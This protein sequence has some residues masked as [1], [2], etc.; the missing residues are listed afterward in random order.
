[1]FNPIYRFVINR[2][3]HKAIVRGFLPAVF[4]LLILG[5]LRSTSA[6]QSQ[7]VPYHV[8]SVKRIYWTDHQLNTQT[9]EIWRSNADG[10]S[11]ERIVFGLR[12][13]RG[14]E[15]DT[16]MSHVYW[17]DRTDDTLGRANFDGTEKSV[18]FCSG[19]ITPDDLVLDL[20]R[21]KMYWTE[22]TA[23]RIRWSSMDNC[24]PQTLSITGGVVEPVGI[25]LAHD[26]IY[27]AEASSKRIKRANLDGTGVETVIA[28]LWTP[29]EMAFDVDAGYMYV[30]ES[31]ENTPGYGGR[32]V[33][34]PLNGGSFVTIVPNLDNPRGIALDLE[35]SHIY[36]ID[37]GKS[38]L[39]R[40]DL[41][42]NNIITIQSGG[43]SLSFARSLALEPEP[44]VTCY[45][46]SLNRT[47]N[48][49]Y[50][51]ASPSNS[52]GC[53]SG[54]YTAGAN[55]NL[56]AQADNGW[57]VGSWSG[58]NSNSSTSNNNSV[59]MPN[60]NHTATV[61][62]VEIITCYSLL[63]QHTGSGSNP[64][65]G[66]GNSSGCPNKQYIAGA[67]INL[68]ANPNSGWV[69]EGWTGTNNNSSTSLS[70]TVTMPS[71]NHTVIAHYKGQTNCYT[72]LLKHTG[73]GNDP[74]PS[75]PSSPDCAV[76]QYRAGALISLTADPAQTW[77]VKSW[78]GT[79]N[80]SSTAE[81]NNVIMPGGSHTVIV[82][83]A[84]PACYLLQLTREGPGGAPTATPANSTGC[85]AGQYL[86]D[87]AIVLTA[88]PS[89]GAEI[90]DWYG[91]ID[92]TA[93]SLTNIVLMPASNHQAGVR[94]R[95]IQLAA[96]RTLLPGVLKPVPVVA[97]TC[98]AGEREIEPNN[99]RPEAG[100]N[101]PFCFSRTYAG[102]P[103]DS[104]D[105]FAYDINTPG[106]INM[107]VNNH[108]GKNVQLILSNINGTTLAYDTNSADGLRASYSLS[109]PGRYF[110][111]L[112][113]PSPNTSETAEY[114]LR[115]TMD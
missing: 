66:P 3:R 115:V 59:T 82:N 93:P 103:T 12:N 23:N 25:A 45:T 15:L 5:P 109:V 19:L 70:N 51:T 49:S 21:R 110:V 80:D 114:S 13:P 65:A 98:Y 106:T 11:L 14:I 18:A 90:V 84:P 96:H 58:T 69:V 34:V 44:K 27:W 47:G 24:S 112:Y 78:N 42:G 22:P 57:K 20:A 31:I 92:N 107:T 101:G 37:H 7:P 63:L 36:W 29:L 97:P 99:S 91:T 76:G 60:N 62:Y 86:P 100:K 4:L 83:Y 1:M 8:D 73:E 61:N 79:T 113:V 89:V 55:I 85:Q 39:Q 48:G 46:L 26:K 77:T 88:S 52:T 6:G 38:K 64:T 95:L 53:S 28:N 87:T 54:K 40:S 32:I 81:T 75:P 68:T 9:G 2:P 17:V 94:Y 102:L 50:P 111:A 56:S 104:W 16:D 10:S 33:R 41:L 35:S 108:R 74:I 43:D 71:A 67:T 72:L 30:T 105:V